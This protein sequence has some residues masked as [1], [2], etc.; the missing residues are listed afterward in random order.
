MHAQGILLA[1]QGSQRDSLATYKECYM[2]AIFLIGKLETGLNP[3]VESN[4]TLYKVQY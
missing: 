1:A 3:F 4:S 2:A